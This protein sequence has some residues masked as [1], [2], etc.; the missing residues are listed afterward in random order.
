MRY[1]LPKSQQSEISARQDYLY[2]VFHLYFVLQSI[3]DG[4]ITLLPFGD[5]EA[6][7]VFIIGHTSQVDKYLVEHIDT[8]TESVVVVT[9]CFPLSLI[10]F[11]QKKELY[12]PDISDGECMLYEGEPFGFGFPISDAELNFYNTF[13]DVY[14]RI[15]AGY[16]KL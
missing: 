12:V 14:T 15:D 3:E 6:D 13:G 4:W 11:A 9:T 2:D 7:I 10:K 8:F 5:D 16:R 1:I